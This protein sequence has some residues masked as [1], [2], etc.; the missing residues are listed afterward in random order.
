MFNIVFVLRRKSST[1][2]FRNNNVRQAEDGAFWDHSQPAFCAFAREFSRKIIKFRKT[3]NG[4]VVHDA[5]SRRNRFE[6]L[7]MGRGCSIVPVAQL[8][9]WLRLMLRLNQEGREGYEV[10]QVRNRT[11]K[12]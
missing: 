4:R 8:R 12:G 3:R 11:Q 7:K 6:R 1:G 2:G 5:S 10:S 9:I